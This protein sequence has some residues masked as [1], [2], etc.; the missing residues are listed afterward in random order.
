MRDD[1]L[2]FIGLA[3]GFADRTEAELRELGRKRDASAKRVATAISASRIEPPGSLYDELAARDAELAATSEEL[4]QQL[5]EL[6]RASLLLERERSKYMDFFLGAPDAYIVTDPKGATQEANTAA[7]VLFGADPDFLIGRPL[8]SFVARQDTH[9]FRDLIRELGRSASGVPRAVTLRMRPR[10]R[11]VFVVQVRA[12]MVRTPAGRPVAIRWML[13]RPQRG[14]HEAASKV[15]YAEVARELSHDLLGPLT[16]ILGSVQLLRTGPGQGE[17]DRRQF[18]AWIDRAARLQQRMLADL[19]E[20]AEVDAETGDDAIEALR[21]SDLIQSVLA[22]Q[23]ETVRARVEVR[24]RGSWGDARVRANAQRLHRALELVVARVLEGVSVFE[25][26]LL[27]TL[28]AGAHAI[29]EIDAID[30]GRAP[31]GWAVRMAIAA[32]TLETCGGSL[33]LND[34]T[35]SVRVTLPLAFAP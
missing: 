13:H 8:I 9:A 12:G 15:A 35:P 25:H 24:T 31:R 32:R 16:T 6:V 1:V 27:I 21:L 2:S 4:Q 7:G 3:R 23:P 17:D 30:E 18:L 19:A 26:P 33:V 22:L 14:E 11:P 20:L 29:V 10:G 5:D 34:E 28:S